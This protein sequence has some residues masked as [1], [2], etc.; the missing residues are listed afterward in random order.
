MTWMRQRRGVSA[1]SGV[2]WFFLFAFLTVAVLSYKGVGVI[3]YPPE[4]ATIPVI[5]AWLNVP[6]PT[7]TDEIDPAITEQTEQ[8]KLEQQVRDLTARV[9]NSQRSKTDLEV[10]LE[11]REQDI[12]TMQADLARLTDQLNLQKDA[13]KQAVAKIYERM[14]AEDAVKILEGMEPERASI[15]IGGMKDDMAAEI[16]AAFDPARARLISDILAGFTPPLESGGVRLPTPTDAVPPGSEPPAPVTSEPIT[17]LGDE[18]V[19]ASGD[20]S[21]E[22]EQK[23]KDEAVRKALAG[24]PNDKKKEGE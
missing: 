14:N 23:K 3:K 18:E 11:Q 1:A 17:V 22:E 16:L 13:Q 4:A 12:L 2:G 15:I 10:Q 19:A 9:E 24:E 6:E 21:D 20:T 8:Q 7:I 5:G